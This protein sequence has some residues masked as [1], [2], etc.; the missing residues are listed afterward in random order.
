MTVLGKIKEAVEER[1]GK[2]VSMKLVR[3]SFLFTIAS[4]SGISRQR[5]IG[6]KAREK[7]INFFGMSFAELGA[8]K[9]TSLDVCEDIFSD[10]T[11]SYEKIVQKN[12]GDLNGPL[13]SGD[14]G[15]TEVEFMV[16]TSWFVPL[17]GSIEGMMRTANFYN[18]TEKGSLNVV[19][20][21]FGSE[22]NKE[23]IPLLTTLWQ[24]A[25]AHGSTNVNEKYPPVDDVPT[26]V[27]L[28]GSPK[29]FRRNES[30]HASLVETIEAGFAR[31]AIFVWNDLEEV[32]AVNGAADWEALKEYAEQVRLFLIEHKMI[33]FS[34]E[35]RKRMKAYEL[36]VMEEYNKT[37]TD[38]NNIRLNSMDLIERIA[39]L[40]AVAELTHEIGLSELENAIGIVEDSIEDM[41]TVVSPETPYKSM[42]EILITHDTWMGIVEMSNYGIRF[43]NK[44]EEKY[45]IEKLDEYA[46][47]KNMRKN[48]SMKGMT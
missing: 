17:R 29:P 26:N 45:Q 2:A 16:P 20:T 13:P 44:N 1:T 3:N 5:F 34:S 38:I 37:M 22:Y 47:Y 23:V 25:K 33:T 15:S 24:S 40:V 18:M 6:T 9:D 32:K 12:F 42:Y 39:A 28:F 11:S 14:T 41:K 30:K 48:I 27:L 43:R 8:G 35:A 21:E 31:R 4:V 36:E 10:A 46:Y 19:S 7:Y